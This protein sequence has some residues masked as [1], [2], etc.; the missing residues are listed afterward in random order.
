MTETWVTADQVMATCA[1]LGLVG[2]WGGYILTQKDTA[3]AKDM[4]LFS[5]GLKA[6]FKRIDDLRDKGEQYVTRAE[7][8]A[9]RS[10]IR[11]D[12]EH[13]MT[14]LSTEVRGLRQDLS[15]LMVRIL[16]NKD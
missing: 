16:G 8:Q 14:P 3:Q 10:E 2:A 5:D 6:A 12:I 1:V 7:L 4:Q 15:G 9:L 11:Q 13:T